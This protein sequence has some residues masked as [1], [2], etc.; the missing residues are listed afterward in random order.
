M[1]GKD[2]L[3]RSAAYSSLNDVTDGFWSVL[4]CYSPFFL[5]LS[6]LPLL[7]MCVCVGFV[8]GAVRVCALSGPLLWHKNEDQAAPSFVLLLVGN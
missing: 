5:S 2:V 8:C 4:S 1:D 7:W 6:V 3:Y